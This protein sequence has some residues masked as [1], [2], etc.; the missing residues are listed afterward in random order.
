MQGKDNYN[1]KEL[2]RTDYA[3][4]LD[5]LLEMDY[6]NEDTNT[7]LKLLT[8]RINLIPCRCTPELIASH[9]FCQTCRLIVDVNKTLIDVFDNKAG[10]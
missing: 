2:T 3:A 9:T 10:K 6:S 7:P 1:K 4:L 8:S 5:E